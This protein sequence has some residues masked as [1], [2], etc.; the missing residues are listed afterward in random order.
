MKG[1]SDASAA[2]PDELV[3]RLRAEAFGRGPEG[4]V[5]LYAYASGKMRAKVGTLDV[6]RRAFGNTLYAPLLTHD[7][8][9]VGQPLVIG[10]SARAE[11]T[12][13]VGDQRVGFLLA[14]VQE[15]RGDRAGRWT[16]SGVVRE[17]VDL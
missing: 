8:L 3:S 5:A 2:T 10:G 6:F 15:A 12:L 14:M 13:T 4:V 7:G 9:E 16:L 11:L 1:P 17:G